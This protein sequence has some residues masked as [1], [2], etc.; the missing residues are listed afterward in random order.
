MFLGFC[1]RAGVIDIAPASVLKIKAKMRRKMRS[2]M[3]WTAR[4]GELPARGAS[5]FIRIFNSKLFEHRADE[6]SDNELTWSK[7]YFPVINTDRSLKAIDHY[8]QECVRY[9]VSGTRGKARF[10]V[11]Y[12]DMKAL[13]LRSLVGEY[14]GS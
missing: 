5:A 3:R 10:R 7:W 14:Y 12:E 2:L 1:Y 8:A 4:K 11:S 6:M 13:G 9:L